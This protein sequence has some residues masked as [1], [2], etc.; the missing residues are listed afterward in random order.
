LQDALADLLEVWLD[1]A[2]ML[3]LALVVLYPTSLALLYLVAPQSPGLKLQFWDLIWFSD[4]GGQMGMGPGLLRML[5]LLAGAI[6][7]I[8]L[9]DIPRS[10]WPC[11]G[12]AALYYGVALAS[13]LTSS[14]PH[15][16]LLAWLDLLNVGLA[17]GLVAELASQRPAWLR[18]LPYLAVLL[19][20]AIIPANYRQF[21]Y[22]PAADEQ[23]RGAF[24]HP[25][26]MA[27]YLILFLPALLARYL[28]DDREADPASTVLFGIASAFAL[29]SIVLSFS[30][31]GQLVALA[32]I[33]GLLV[34]HPASSWIRL[35]VRGALAGCLGLAAALLL[36]KGFA[37]HGPMLV[38]AVALFLGLVFGLLRAWARPLPTFLRFL[39]LVALVLVM[40]GSMD[41]GEGKV[42]QHAGKRAQTLAQGTDNSLLARLAF[43][44]A[45]W[46]IALDHP[47]LGVGPAGFQRYY[48]SYQQ[49]LNWFSK[50]A[51]N[52]PLN[53]LA[54]TGFLGLGLAT[55]LAL[56]LAWA[57]G[58]RLLREPAGARRDV[59]AGITVGV[60]AFLLYSCS[61]V[62][63][64]FRVLPLTMGM[65]LGLALGSP[66]GETVPELPPV[67][68]EVSPW[69]IRPQVLLQHTCCVLL[70]A[71]VFFNFVVALGDER[72]RYGK[73]ATELGKIKEAALFYR[74]ALSIDPWQGEHYRQCALS[75]LTAGLT[76]DKLR[77]EAREM[78]ERVVQLDSH[79]AVGYNLLG[80]IY[81]NA[82]PQEKAADAYRQALQID[83]I[84]YPSFYID[85][86]NDLL[87]RESN[88]QARLLLLATLQRFPEEAFVTMFDF[89]AK[90]IRMQLA[91]AHVLLG[92][93]SN[94]VQNPVAAEGYFAHAVKLNDKT[95][96]GLFGLGV[97]LYHQ[98][99]WEDALKP[100]ETLIKLEPGY[101]P[102]LRLARD[103]YAALGRQAEVEALDKQIN[104]P[105]SSPPS[106]RPE[107]A[108]AASPP[109][110]R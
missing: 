41:L 48:P 36:L 16:A 66:E 65:L 43:W 84:N 17:T 97:A 15:D 6:W 22:D 93:L 91:D 39:G 105:P 104:S 106:G 27:S 10:A 59:R 55:L 20:L 12:L 3:L 45:A 21:L 75:L 31:A 53:I 74:E 35:L 56:G 108:P 102:G 85:L 54:E 28:H 58:R 40:L 34:L 81:A 26:I 73:T 63:W 72:A 29:G 42:S 100:A 47:A 90:S 37:A 24:F 30:R 46:E 2:V 7:L 49:D 52:L 94:P 57:L 86:A 64:E 25:N 69:T 71:M 99:R 110:G 88:E 96:L 82:G 5:M 83:D 101:G 32:A 18:R 4:A 11:L 1:R 8:K 9:R 95:R 61:D 60:G 14:H 51:H 78:A 80:R 107:P 67:E 33:L 89:R 38:A 23:M 76:D 68:E 44:K 92:D 13:A 77:K 62:Q 87:T 98:K 79:R 19:T 50:F 109:A 103:I 70:L